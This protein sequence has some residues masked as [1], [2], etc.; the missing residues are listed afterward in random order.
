MSLDQQ[1]RAPF[2]E[3]TTERLVVS[4]VDTRHDSSIVEGRRLPSWAPDF[5]APGDLEIAA[6]LRRSGLPQGAD[7]SF[8]SRLVIERATGLIVGGV[9]FLGPPTHGRLEIGY[10]IVPSRQR[11]G[12]ATEAV[13]A[14]VAFAFTFPGVTGVFADAEAE[15]VA[16]VG[17]LERIGMSYQFRDGALV[18]YAAASPRIL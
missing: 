3:L 5:P 8:G 9:G 4:L 7:A 12:Y 6:M 16:S 14:M 2:A 15:N 11:R 10:G 1:E 13:L 18:R 17:V